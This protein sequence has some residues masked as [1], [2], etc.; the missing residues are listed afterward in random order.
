M[1]TTYMSCTV[2]NTSL[3]KKEI[4]NYVGGTMYVVLIKDCTA[5]KL[6]GSDYLLNAINQHG[7]VVIPKRRSNYVISVNGVI[8]SNRGNG[9]HA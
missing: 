3:G 8:V 5:S 2:S 6:M 4:N 1:L 7:H 9:Q